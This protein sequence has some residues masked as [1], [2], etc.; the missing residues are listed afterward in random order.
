[1][2]PTALDLQSGVEKQRLR[3]ERIE[4]KGAAA[5]VSWRKEI[6]SRGST[7]DGGGE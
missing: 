7:V 1:M 5:M 6:E 4:V 3:I 2:G